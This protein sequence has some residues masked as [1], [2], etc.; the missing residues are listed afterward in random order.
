M[1]MNLKV[2]TLKLGVTGVTS[3]TEVGL[4]KMERLGVTIRD[5]LPLF[6][7]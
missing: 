5:I 1:Y 3:Q 6:L 7:P 2:T 4:I